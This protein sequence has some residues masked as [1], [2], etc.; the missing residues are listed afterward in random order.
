M[1]LLICPSNLQKAMQADKD[2][3]LGERCAH[4]CSYEVDFP[5]R[6]FVCMALVM[7]LTLW[8]KSENT[9]AQ[10]NSNLTSLS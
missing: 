10:R 6:S 8:K 7:W 4:N 3:V 1:A 2:G 5:I 9:L